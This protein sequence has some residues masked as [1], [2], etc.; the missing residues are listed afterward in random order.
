MEKSVKIVIAVLIAGIIVLLG[1]T[2]IRRWHAGGVQEVVEREQKTCENQ[3]AELTNRITALEIELAQL[4]R[5]ELPEQK[6]AEAMGDAAGFLAHPDGMTCEEIEAQIM[7]LMTYLD[8]R[9]YMQSFQEKG[10]AMALYN[11]VIE[12]LSY[13]PPMLSGELENLASLIRNVTHMYR[14]LGKERI[15]LIKALL[16]NESEIIESVLSIF[17]RYAVT[18]NLC[19]RQALNTPS[20]EVMYQYAG[21]FLNTLAGRSYLLRRDSKIRIL[22]SYY[23]ILIIDRANDEMLNRYGVDIRPFIDYTYYEIASHKGMA[24]Q[25]Q[26]IARLAELREKYK[27]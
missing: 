2:Q 12:R 7:S 21:Y 5:P 4:S 24:Y 27:L 15:T 26:Y 22:T 18:G 9:E 20:L 11:D 23:A 13:K 6:L 3:I 10:G 16:K 1:Y 14:Q 25:R 17:Y 19:R 8:D